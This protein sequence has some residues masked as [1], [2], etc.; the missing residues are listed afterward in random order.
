M[1]DYGD[2]GWIREYSFGL[3][4]I[5]A[6]TASPLVPEMPM[7]V[8]ADPHHLRTIYVLQGTSVFTVDALGN[9]ITECGLYPGCHIEDIYCWEVPPSLLRRFYGSTGCWDSIAELLSLVCKPLEVVNDEEDASRR[10]MLFF[11]F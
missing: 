9:T 5:W 8:L 3:S 2:C 7:M 4:E 10:R 11:R 6:N 1:D